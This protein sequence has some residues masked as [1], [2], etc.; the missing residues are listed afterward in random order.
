MNLRRFYANQPDRITAWSRN[1]TFRSS[2]LTTV[3]PAPSTRALFRRS[4]RAC[5]IEQ[6]APPR[7]FV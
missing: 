3:I 1:F 7:C 2:W 4:A 6:Q 5:G